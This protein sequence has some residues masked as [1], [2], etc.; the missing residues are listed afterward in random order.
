MKA[1]LNERIGIG[2]DGEL[3]ARGVV[4]GGQGLGLGVGDG[5]RWGRKG[6]VEVSKPNVTT[7]RTANASHKRRKQGAK[8]AW[9]IPGCGSTF[10]RSLF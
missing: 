9:S 3:V 7:G 10:T 4:G 2:A 1:T 6:R 8:L 5:N